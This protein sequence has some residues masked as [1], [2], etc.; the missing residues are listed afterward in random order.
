MSTGTS[1]VKVS[2]K[3]SEYVTLISP[4]RSLHLFRPPVAPQKALCLARNQ[5]FNSEAFFMLTKSTQ[6]SPHSSQK[7]PIPL[8]KILIGL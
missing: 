1:R 4:S 7:T 2:P 6:E 5:S 3:K 8:G